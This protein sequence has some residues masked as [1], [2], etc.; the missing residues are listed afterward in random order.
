VV[1]EEI[2]YR[3]GGENDPL[4]QD[5]NLESILEAFIDFIGDYQLINDSDHFLRV[6][7]I[8]EVS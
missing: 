7:K 2:R 5:Y 1:V 3:L 8:T 6:K 4:S